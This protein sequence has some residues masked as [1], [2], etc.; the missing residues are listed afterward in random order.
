MVCVWTEKA[1][2]AFASI[3][4]PLV[5]RKSLEDRQLLPMG[6]YHLAR[7]RQVQAYL[8]VDP[9]GW[10]HD[11]SDHEHPWSQLDSEAVLRGRPLR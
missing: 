9:I 5:T 3:L 7:L 6:A 2:L 10:N 8:A 11:G 4:F 1:H